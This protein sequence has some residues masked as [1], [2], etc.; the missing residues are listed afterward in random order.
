MLAVILVLGATAYL[1][2]AVNR[3]L[4]QASSDRIRNAEVL[5]RAKTA[6]IGYVAKEVLDL[7]E[8]VPGRFPCPESPSDA[9]G[10]NEGRAGSSCDPTYPTNKTVGRLPWRTLGIDKLVDASGEPLWY[11]VSPNWVLGGSIPIINAGTRGLLS[12]DGQGDVVAAIIAPGKALKVEP[13]ANQAAAGCAARTQARNDRSHNS[14]FAANPDYRDYLECQNASAPID[15]NFGV[16]VVDNATHPVTNDQIVYIT[17]GEVLNAMQGPLAERVQRTVAPL[18]SEFGDRWISGRKFLP[19]AFPFTPPESASSPDTHCGPSAAAQKQEG[20]LPIAPAGGTTCS[21]DW[22]SFSISGSGIESKG[23]VADS[24]SRTVT[25]QF[26]YFSLTWVGSLL[27]TLLGILTSSSVTATMDAVA[28]HAAASFRE[29]FRS[30]DVNI[31]PAS[32]A[33]VASLNFVPQTDG[34]ARLSMQVRIDEANLCV[35]NLIDM[36]LCALLGPVLVDE[37]TVSVRYPQLGNPVLQGTMLPAAVAPTPP[38]SFDLLNPA[39]TDP[40]YWF[41]RNEWYRY[42]YYA[43]APSASAAGPG[44]GDLRVN[45]FPAEFGAADD[46]HF[47]LVLMGPAVTGQTRSATASLN[48]YIEGENAAVAASPRTFAYR[49]FNVSGN[50]RIA[51]CPFVA[52]LPNDC[53]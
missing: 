31:S 51:T 19:Y 15:G 52:G 48:Q 43:V 10:A 47:V 40:H 1:V 9:G 11:A 17:A 16:A 50:D 33:Q 37:R 8:S 6:L 2:A 34:D 30:S 13:N 12:V 42:T 20:L 46:K 35:D 53:N 45:G 36:V 14:A 29:P 24:A 4:N 23:C 3:A 32:S 25:C 21:S 22:T 41:F 26:N 7:S 39:S 5:Q 28:P 44:G 49:V 38:Y 27:Q 18:L